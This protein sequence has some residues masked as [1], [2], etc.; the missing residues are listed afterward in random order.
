M[1]TDKCWLLL[2]FPTSQLL[3]QTGLR[4]RI[5]WRSISK[6]TVEKLKSFLEISIRALSIRGVGRLV[7]LTHGKEKVYIQ[8]ADY[9][10][11]FI[12]Q[13]DYR[14]EPVNKTETATLI[15]LICLIYFTWT[16]KIFKYIIFLNIKIKSKSNKCHIRFSRFKYYVS[17]INIIII[18]A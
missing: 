7:R 9:S 4:T 18:I 17:N 6:T 16:I 2:A 10:D 11:S 13:Y 8:F 12:Y 1:S 15:S 5:F 14:Y 3:D